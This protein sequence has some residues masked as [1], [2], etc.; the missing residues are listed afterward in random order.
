MTNDLKR[1][2]ELLHA[3]RESYEQQRAARHL[4]RDAREI[5]KAIRSEL[6]LLPGKVH[7]LDEPHWEA[8]SKSRRRELTHWIFELQGILAALPAPAASAEAPNA[9]DPFATEAPGAA[10]PR[11]AAEAVPAAIPETEDASEDAPQPESGAPDDECEPLNWL[12]SKHCANPWAIVGVLLWTAVVAGVVLFQIVGRW[13]VATSVQLP[14]SQL[15]TWRTTHAELEQARELEQQLART[16]REQQLDLQLLGPN[17]PADA[18]Q[19]VALDETQDQLEA[20]RAT[21]GLAQARHSASAAALSSAPEGN[22]E[23]ERDVLIMILLVGALGG[24]LRVFASL[25]RY[26]GN[27]R[28]VGSW[29]T[30]YLVQPVLGAGLAM[31]VTLLVRAGFLAP[32]SPEGGSALEHVNLLGFYAIAAMTGCFA[33]NA[34]DKL[35]DIFRAM[36]PSNQKD[37]DDLQE[38][39]KAAGAQSQPAVN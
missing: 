9:D 12:M 2:Q 38:K 33:K 4:H 7:G 16:L 25:V 28:F 26:V 22:P 32:A 19:R 3:V 13:T 6:V 14:A 8:L 15:S 21:V 24:C 36:L 1:V 10:L 35:R 23:G 37:K 11:A 29:L 17:P 18:P 30:F 31:V 5:W 20:S 34:M 39:P 27:R